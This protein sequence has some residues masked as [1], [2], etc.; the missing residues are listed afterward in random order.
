MKIQG[1]CS[2]IVLAA[3]SRTK[4]KSSRGGNITFYLFYSYRVLYDPW[5][6]PL[7]LL[8]KNSN[9]ENL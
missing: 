6:G 1:N 3:S 7:R 8:E 4:E 5:D 9:A 2:E